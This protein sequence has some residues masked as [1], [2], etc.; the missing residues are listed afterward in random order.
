MGVDGI[1]YKVPENILKEQ[2]ILKYL[3][4]HK[5]CPNS[6]AKF[7][8][9]FRTR[10]SYYLQME[11][12]GVSL[13]NFV[14]KAH[15]SIKAGEIELS[16]W[17]KVVRALLQQMIE[18]LEYI[19]SMNIVHFDISLENWLINDV[20]VEVD[21]YMDGAVKLRFVTDDIQIKLCDFGLAELFTKS[22]CLT[23]KWCGKRN[24]K[25]PEVA[26]KK[27]H[28]DAK[29]NDIWCFG[30]C[31]F[32]ISVGCHPFDIAHESDEIF[33]YVFEHSIVDLLRKWN[34]IH[35]VDPTLVWL[36]HSIFQFEQDRISLQKIKKYAQ[37]F[38][39]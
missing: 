18:C 14:Q 10:S 8:R 11:D 3:T 22:E 17:H 2:C 35:F 13:F 33:S 16:E 26:M 37:D 1:L 25:S 34:M 29:K 39:Y 28:F 30:I 6:I 20:Q 38:V 36:F 5:K 4:Q 19:H 23:N 24:Y 12:G 27:K 7:E 15:R 32:I 31:L 9:F 21:E